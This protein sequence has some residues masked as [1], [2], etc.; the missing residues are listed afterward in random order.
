MRDGIVE[1]VRDFRSDPQVRAVLITAEG[2]AL[3]AGMDLA[4]DRRPSRQAGIAPRTT[5]GAARRC[6]R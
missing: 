1:T 6:R 4:L 3:C 5:S 2:D